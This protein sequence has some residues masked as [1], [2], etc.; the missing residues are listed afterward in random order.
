[1][2]KTLFLLLLLPLLGGGLLS[3]QTVSNLS[4][5]AGSPSTVTFDVEWDEATM[6][7][8]W[9][10]TMWVFVD[11]NKN[12]KMTRMLITGGTLTEHSGTAEFI[13]ENTMGAW[14]SGDA[15]TNGSFSATVQLLTATADL[16]GACAYASSYPPV[17]NYVSES[18]IVFAGTPWYEIKLLHEDGFTVE[19]IE[20]GGTFLLPCSYTVSSFTDATGA[21]GKINCMKP[22]GLS[23]T[24]TPAAICAGESSTLT[25][26]AAGAASYSINGID[27]YASPVFYESPVSPTSYTLYAQT[28]EGCVASKTSAAVVMVNPLPTNLSLTASPATICLGAS[29]TLTASATHGAEYSINNSTWQPETDFNESPVSAA[30]YTLCVK[31]SA[32][33]SASVTDAAV[34]TIYPA[35]TPGTIT[36]ASTTTDKDA[37]P[38]VTIDNITAADGGNGAI[39][40]QWRRSGDSNAT[41][42]GNAATY[43]I[44]TDA[45]NYSTAGTHN[46]N[47][48]AKDATC[49]TAWVAAAGTYTL[50]VIGPPG[51]FSTT[52]CAQ[53]CWDGD[54]VDPSAGT[55]VNC[56]VTTNLYP[57][58]TAATN[59]GVGWNGYANSPLISGA[60]GP[61]SDKNGRRNT[62]AIIMGTYDVVGK[63]CKDLGEGWYLPAYEELEN[64]SEGSDSNYPPLN[65]LPGAN[66]I[67]PLVGNDWHWSSTESYQNGGRHSSN[68]TTTAVILFSGGAIYTYNKNGRAYVQCAWRP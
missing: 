15:R 28:A 60:S 32:G 30:S 63:L 12:G 18:E 64:M 66:L 67:V 6:P 51:T 62:D 31:T 20:S 1:M 49:N 2:K 23:L 59:T 19:T 52:L 24:A 43:T 21:P 65:G 48:Y 55:W 41:L 22:T 47:R 57:F 44:G 54:A 58:H 5:S 37:D 25:A 56:Y 26:Y 38:N 8:L 50:Y 13:P 9:S 53:C 7:A 4:V 3:A 14:V 39:T 11:Y 68:S 33:C 34:V 35:F 46:F 10:D 16:Y 17:A 36:T 40:Y 27:W 42:T 45:D 61:G 29:A